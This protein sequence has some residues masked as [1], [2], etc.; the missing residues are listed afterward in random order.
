M[1]IAAMNWAWRQQVAPTV[2]LVLM[3]LADAADD[4][5][6][7]WPSIP[8]VARKCG[9]TTRTVQR[10]MRGLAASGRLR[11]EPRFRH[12]GSHSSNRYTLVLDGEWLVSAP[13][14]TGVSTPGPK[15]REGGDTDVTPGTASKSKREPPR[16]PLKTFVPTAPAAEALADVVDGDDGSGD[17]HDRQLEY[18]KGLSEVEWVEARK[19][20]ADLPAEPG[21]AVPR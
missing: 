10:I 9:V 13:P 14:D 2:K 20:L 7:C 18:P 15:R 19:K 12:D 17:H 6:V 5:G 11:H 3:S 4:D 8:T 16:P 1:S 21:T